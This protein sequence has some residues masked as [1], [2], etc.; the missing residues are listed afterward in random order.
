[1]RIKYIGFWN[2]CNV[3]T[4]DGRIKWYKDEIKEVSD[5]TGTQLIKN[6]DYIKVGA[7]STPKKIEKKEEVE[8]V[9]EIEKEE[10]KFDLDGDGDVDSDDYSIAAKTLSHAR[11]SK[12]DIEE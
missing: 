3:N 1:M 2:P 12:K 9:I 5:K 4:S 6:A 7:S 10:I 8:K 11:K